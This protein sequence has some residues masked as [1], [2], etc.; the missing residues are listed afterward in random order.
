MGGA[1]DSSGGVATKDGSARGTA[2][3]R[4]TTRFAFAGWGQN[5]RNQGFQ[6]PEARR[7]H[8]ALLLGES[9]SRF[10]TVSPPSR[11]PVH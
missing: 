3:K 10:G 8:K 7:R 9:A 2:A 1:V 11:S 4:L 5:G 6:A